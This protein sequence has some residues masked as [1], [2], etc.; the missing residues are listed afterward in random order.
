MKDS[1]DVMTDIISLFDVDAFKANIT[2]KIYSNDKPA[3][4]KLIDVVVNCPGVTNAQVQ[5][6]FPN[7]NIHAPN[8]ASGRPDAI[9][10]R[11]VAKAI[12]PYLDTQFTDTFHTNI[13]DGGGL[14][15]DTD[16]SWFYNIPINY[17]S[18]QTNFKNL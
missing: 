12:F 13:E 4:S 14:I 16:G 1:F 9:T 2:G 5:K 18:V 7:V 17:Y 10:L 11:K 3:G 8:L 6:S 15:Q